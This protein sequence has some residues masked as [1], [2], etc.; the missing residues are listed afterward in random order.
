MFWYCATRID[1]CVRDTNYTQCTS[2]VPV[3]WNWGAWCAQFS[4]FGN[5]VTEVKLI[6]TLLWNRTYGPYSLFQSFIFCCWEESESLDTKYAWQFVFLTTV[7]KLRRAILLL[8]ASN[9]RLLWS[10]K[11]LVWGIAMKCFLYCS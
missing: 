2:V 5:V 8:D 3:H 9:N 4:Y 6:S 10:E 1:R 11:I 7:L